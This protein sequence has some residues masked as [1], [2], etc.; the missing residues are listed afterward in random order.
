MSCA[1]PLRAW[2]STQRKSHAE[3]CLGPVRRQPR[4][5]RK[6][7]GLHRPDGTRPG[8]RSRPAGAA[9]RH[10]RTRHHGPADRAQGR[11]A[12]GRPLHHPPAGSQPRL[13]HGHHDVRPCPHGRRPGV[14]H[15]GH[16]AR[17]TDRVAVPQAAP[18]RR[19]HHEGIHQRHPGHGDPA[20]IGDRGAARG[21]DDLL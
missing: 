1:P 13:G 7:A 15:A 9:R 19:L 8:G 10:P 21:P 17:R 6:C 2:A 3:S 16:A 5:G 14:E 11:A 20:A 18:V 12:A 4:L